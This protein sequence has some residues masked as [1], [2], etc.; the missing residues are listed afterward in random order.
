MAA[1]ARP[2]HRARRRTAAR[3]AC[4]AWSP[5]S[6]RASAPRRRSASADQR[7]RDVAAV[8]SEYVWEADARWR[9]TYLSERV[10]AVLGYPRAELLGRRPW[11][12]MPLG[13][14]RAVRE[15]FAEPWR[16]RRSRSATSCTAS[17]TKSGGVIWQSV[18]GV[19]L[20]DADGR[21]TGYR[22]TAADVT[23][24]KQ[25]EARIEHLATR[26]ALTGLANRALLADRAAQAILRRGAQ[27]L[28][29][30]AARASTST[31]SSW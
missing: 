25:A 18:S 27:P 3:C 23:P 8:S 7:F 14:E 12:F 21:W 30:R 13:E 11:E 10:E 15:W 31:A 19:P 2:R 9:Y 28:A 16:R 5:T 4:R 1:R 29:A 6:T 24:R 20:H 22:G 17:M 26:D